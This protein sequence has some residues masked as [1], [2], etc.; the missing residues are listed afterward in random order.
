MTAREFKSQA[1]VGTMISGPNHCGN[2]CKFIDIEKT[3]GKYTAFCN[4]YSFELKLD[5][6]RKNFPWKRCTYCKTFDCSG[7]IFAKKYPKCPECK[8]TSFDRWGCVCRACE[9]C[10]EKRK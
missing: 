8:G 7:K 10:G 5:T 9:G 4:L 1:K 6:K 3:L 2:S